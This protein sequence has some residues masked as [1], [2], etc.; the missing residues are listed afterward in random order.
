MPTDGRWMLN[1]EER[2]N[3]QAYLRAH[4]EVDELTL[5]PNVS[6]YAPVADWVEG[7]A[8][9]APGAP[10]PPPEPEPGQPPESP[11]AGLAVAPE[12]AGSEERTA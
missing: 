10:E 3:R 9:G 6:G 7:R 4:P 2:A 1:A 11:A 5:A 8:A 12:P